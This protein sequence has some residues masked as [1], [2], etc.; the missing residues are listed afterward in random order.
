MNQVSYIGYKQPKIGW[1]VQAVQI[2]AEV[3]PIIIT[4]INK[5][6]PNPNDW[7]GWNALDSQNGYPIGTQ[8]TGW[9]IKDGQSVHNEALNIL[10]YIQNYGTANVLG[11]NAHWGRS[12]TEND[13]AN[14]L[15]RGGYVNEANQLL[16]AN[17]TQA[18]DNVQ[19][20]LQKNNWLLYAGLGLTIF[21]LLR[22]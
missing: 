7:M 19:Q 6:K 14:K 17:K 22:K 2:A 16:S 13:I 8:V 1:I 3:I 4:S 9:I 11:Y 10:Q 18:I 15:K 21:I 12:I 20:T 5:G